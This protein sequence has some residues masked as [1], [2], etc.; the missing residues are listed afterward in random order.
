MLSDGN[1]CICICI[2]ISKSS[3]VVCT[4][5]VAQKKNSRGLSINKNVSID[6]TLYSLH[7]SSDSPISKGGQTEMLADQRTG[8]NSGPAP[9]DYRN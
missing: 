3:R 7:I 8:K 9:A 1:K 4:V 6:N 2:C 5:G